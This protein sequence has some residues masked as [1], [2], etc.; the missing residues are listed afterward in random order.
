MWFVIKRLSLGIFLIALTSSILLVGDWHRRKP[1]A[2]RIPQIAVLIYA[3]QPVLLDGAQGMIEGL[4]ANGF[5]DKQSIALTQYNAEGDLATVNSIAKQITDSRFDLALTMGTPAMQAVANANKDGK[6]THIFGLVADP[7][8]AGVGLKREDPLAH[9]KHLVGIGT[10]L[11]VANSFQLAK[12]FF[13]DLKSVG[14]VWNPG[15]S[16]SR[17]FTEQA[18]KVAQQLGIELLEATAD[19]SSAVVEAANSSISRGAQA[20]WIGGDNTVL[21][22]LQPVIATAKKAHLPVFTITPGNPQRGTLFDQGADFREVGKQTGELAAQILRGADSASIP[23]RNVVPEKLVINKLA[24]S[25]LADPWRLPEEA[26][27]RAD[28]FVDEAGVHEKVSTATLQPSSN[29]MFKVGIVYFAPEP[30]AESCMQGLSDGL[31]D[32]GFVEGKN[33]E[34]R[35]AHAQGEIINIPSMFQNYDNQDLDVIV[36]MT[37]PCLTAACSTVKKTPVV[38]MYVYDPVAAGAGTSFTDHLPHVTGVGSFPPVGETL[39]VIQQLIPGVR[40]V[41]TLY[42]NA[43]ANSRKVVSVAR[44]MFRQRNITLEEVAITNT[45]EVFQAAQALTQ[46]NIQAVWISGDN[47]ALQAFPSIVKAATDARLPVINNDP[48]FVDQGALVSVGIGWR[49]TGLAAAK[50]VARVLRGEKPQDVP[51]ENVAVRKT[52][53]NQQMASKLGITFPETLVKEAEATAAPQ[54]SEQQPPTPLAKKWN[55]NLVEFN[56]VLDVEE[57]EQG[58]LT[59][60][61]EANLV[62][63][64][65]Y[66]VKIRNAQGDMGTVN[67]LIDA[68]VSDEADLLITLSTP[69]LQ[70]ALQRARSLPIVFTYVA[71]GVI[72]GAGRSDEDHLPNVTGVYLGGGYKELLTIIRE[73]FPSVHTLGTLFVPS[74]VNSVFHKDQ[75]MAAAQK[76]GIEVIAVAASTSAEVPDAALSLCSRPIDALCQIPANLTASAFPSIAQAAR[77]TKLPIFA[78]QSSQARSGAAVVL[79]RDYEDGG[80]E[81]GLMAAKVMRGANPAT[82]PFQLVS[83]TKLIVNREAARNSGLILPAALIKQA[84]EVIGQ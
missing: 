4:A 5:I 25:G 40:S 58:V 1:T 50:V 75:L 24:L 61:R 33:L 44:E 73:S 19:N 83:R 56:N 13:P 14:V 77:R 36:S 10:L 84:D 18:R 12:E 41:G 81:A 34:V 80:R 68:A 3:S 70:A 57:A 72:A 54:T 7:F 20:L 28:I 45:S 48:E 71:N 51:F 47:T 8:S 43:E 17:V 42:N 82:I 29:R 49:Q 11:P 79:A 74:E 66:E 65:D 69:T 67:S 16:N 59:G 60:L 76:V 38:F 52:M 31:R 32:L 37:T 46:R 62:E 23:I 6:V 55:V 26:T 21:S 53:L 39:D 22:A 30:G 78:F 27:A 63:G 15:E 9:P 35:K 64:R 2:G